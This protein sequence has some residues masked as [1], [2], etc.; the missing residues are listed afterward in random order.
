MKRGQ[1]TVFLALLLSVICGLLLTIIEST[2]VGAMRMQLE[3]GM[4][5]SIHSIFAEYSRALL[6]RYDLFYIDTSYGEG[7]A[8]IENTEGHI[9][10][11]MKA[12]QEQ[13]DRRIA[14][15]DWFRLSIQEIKV[16]DYLLASDYEGRVFFRQAVHYMDQ[17]ASREQIPDGRSI[18]QSMQSVRMG[19]ITGRRIMSELGITEMSV[20][21]EISLINA[22]RGE[23]ILELVSDGTELSDRTADVQALFSHRAIQA[24]TKKTPFHETILGDRAERLFDE[25]IFHKCSCLTESAGEGALCYEIEYIVAGQANDRENLSQIAEELL[26]LRETANAAYLFQDNQKKQEAKELAVLLADGLEIPEL[27]EALTDSILY[28][29]GYAEAILDVNRLMNQGCVPVMKSAEDWRLPLRDLLTFR[30]YMGDGGGSGLHY[31]EYLSVYLAE[32]EAVQ[33]RKRCMDIIEANIRLADGNRFFRMDG[34]VEYI[35]A[36]AG[37]GSDYGYT[38]DITRSYGYETE[39]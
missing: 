26:K 18:G 24:G 16:R 9:R 19:D 12:N 15:G 30:N 8:A 36:Y 23:D 34:C 29:W 39:N 13:N 37:T 2:R 11:Y 20:P 33:K 22:L 4:D 1:I 38:Y 27:I 5:L 3:S 17:Y 21:E 28:A 25:Y 32:T 35:N 7:T 14:S 10:E 6:S 31:R